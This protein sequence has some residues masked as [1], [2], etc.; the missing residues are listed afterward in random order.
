DPANLTPAVTHESDFTGLD[1]ATS[2]HLWIH[3][4]D[5]WNRT[6]AV[7]LTAT[8]DPLSGP[9][10]ASVNGSEIFVAGQPLFPVALWDDCTNLASDHI[11]LGI[12]LFIGEGCDHEN[13]LA[14][15]LEG[16]AYAV[17]SAQS[18]IDPEPGII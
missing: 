10:P 4:T 5:A 2:Y 6:A 12:N 15:S 18:G 7:E 8:T 13:L 3:A 1:P 17:V 11:A 9:T 14:S 16:R